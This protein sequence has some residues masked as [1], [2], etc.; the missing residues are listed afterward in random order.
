M[1]P[2][3]HPTMKKIGIIGRSILGKTAAALALLGLGAPH[4]QTI[5]AR[6]RSVGQDLRVST[7]TQASRPLR[8]APAPAPAARAVVSA[9]F[10]GVGLPRWRGLTPKEWGMSPDCRRM[11]R[12]SRLRRAGVAGSR[13]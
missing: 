10:G 5:D 7:Q 8:A 3:P 4:P 9:P 13:I 2:F 1:N 12:K 11:V 6:T